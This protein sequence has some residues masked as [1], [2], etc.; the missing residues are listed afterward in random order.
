[1]R[2]GFSTGTAASAAAYGAVCLLLSG[3]LPQTINVPL[4][5]F[6]F[7]DGGWHPS[8]AASLS[9]PTAH[10]QIFPSGITRANVVKDGGDD[11]DATHGITISAYASRNPF[12]PALLPP[13][14]MRPPQT[15][16][17]GP[18]VPALDGPL[19]ITD[20]PNQIFLYAGNGIGSVTLPGLPV[21]PGEAAI[22]PEPRKQISHAACLAAKQYGYAEPLHLLITAEEGEKRALR[23]LNARLGI[24]GGISILGTRGTVR[25]YSNNAWKDSIRQGL[26]VAAALGIEELLL[27]TG[28]RSERLAFGLHPNL[29]PQ[30]GILAADFAAFTLREAGARP[31]RHLHWVCFPGKLLKLAQGL[32]WT[33]AS[34]G[35]TDIPM[36]TRL[37]LE[38]GAPEHLAHE[39]EAMPTAAGAFGLLRHFADLPLREKILTALAEKALT[40]A[41]KWLEEAAPGWTKRNHLSLYV[42]SLEEELLLSR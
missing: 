32:E 13:V 36:L 31:F 19:A 23:T 35:A 28:R 11:P 20:F 1:M 3:A 37:F 41:R 15:V 8:Q 30:A 7:A 14:A 38:A 33:H 12:D 10:G 24:V 22:N 39:A 42:F 25:P 40:F 29:P 18:S 34:E 5:P 9:I 16:G 27:C 26:N 17:V 4:P 6:T 2:E 21:S